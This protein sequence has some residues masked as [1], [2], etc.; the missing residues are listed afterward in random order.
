MDATSRTDSVPVKVDPDT[1]TVWLYGQATGARKALVTQHLAALLS[2]GR[3]DITVDLTGATGLSNALLDV[4]A[5]IACLMEPPRRLI[6]HAPASLGI[7][8]RLSAR[9]PKPDSPSLA[10]RLTVLER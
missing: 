4:F 3:D 2:E 8:Q 1:S 7:A 5:A 6:V 10:L 9:L